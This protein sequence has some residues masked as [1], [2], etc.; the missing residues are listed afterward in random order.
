LLRECKANN[1]IRHQV[2]PDTYVPLKAPF[3]LTGSQSGLMVSELGVCWCGQPK[4]KW[5]AICLK[6]SVRG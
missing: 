6:V 3:R 1:F 4:L 5:H 2:V